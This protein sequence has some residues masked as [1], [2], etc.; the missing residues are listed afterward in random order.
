MTAKAQ[1]RNVLVLPAPSV[2]PWL[3]FASWP[4]QA[5]S[6][7]AVLFPLI[8]T[9]DDR[10]NIG[11]FY[12]YNPI[13]VRFPGL[14][15]WLQPRHQLFRLGTSLRDILCACSYI[16]CRPIL[17]SVTFSRTGASHKNSPGSRTAVSRRRYAVLFR[18]P[19]SRPHWPVSLHT[20]NANYPRSHHH[21]GFS[22]HVGG[23]GTTLVLNR[24]VVDVVRRI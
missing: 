6:K 18:S 22:P 13:L 20:Y 8:V 11:Q 12:C 16:S 3:P 9:I 2:T 19:N 1:G 4:F 24:W 7:E 23:R 15:A 17:S 14:L 10:S 5:R 21:K